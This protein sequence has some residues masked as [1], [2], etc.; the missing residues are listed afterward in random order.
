MKRNIMIDIETM[1]QSANAAIV[2]IGAVAFDACGIGEKLYIRISLED[3]A[4]YGQIDA[5]TILWW[6]KQGD[7]SRSEITKN[8]TTSPSSAADILS[9]FIETNSDDNGSVSIWGNGSDFDNVILSNWYKRIGKP[10]PWKFWENRCYR[11]I[12]SLFKDIKLERSGTHHN[13]LDDA[14]SQAEHLIKI[15]HSKN[16]PL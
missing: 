5:S 6:L 14:V 7:E 2:S 4:E 13:A 12:K 8:D 16:L 11:T 9:S 3:A 1:G 15:A 10:V